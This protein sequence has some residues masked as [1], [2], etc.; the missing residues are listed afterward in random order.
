[1]PEGERA[2][3]DAPETVEPTTG[4]LGAGGHGP[5]GPGGVPDAKAAP[6]LVAYVT[7]LGLGLLMRLR[8]ARGDR[9]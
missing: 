1:M 8:G 7:Q 3:P 9:T 2:G 6:G 5:D 4:R